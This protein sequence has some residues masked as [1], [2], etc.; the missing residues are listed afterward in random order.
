[1]YNMFLWQFMYDLQKLKQERKKR[2]LS[3]DEKDLESLSKI[4]KKSFDDLDIVT[5]E[6]PQ[7]KSSYDYVFFPITDGGL[8]QEEVEAM[9]MLLAYHFYKNGFDEKTSS[10]FAEK[11]GIFTESDRGGGFLTCKLNDY[12][13]NNIYWGNQF[14]ENLIGT[15]G[16][17]FA[18]T[19]PGYQPG[20]KLGFANIPKNIEKTV[21]CDDIISTGKTIIT[22][23]DIL[24]SVGITPLVFYSAAEK[25]EYKG[26]ENIKKAYPFLPVVTLAK[27][28]LNLETRKTEVVQNS[29]I[30]Y[31]N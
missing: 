9:G 4:V 3:L 12:L 8:K 14:S 21:L 7:G 31:E 5:Y 1:M 20:T 26:R 13:W 28:H 19:F 25:I 16:L 24:I 22:V 23:A 18:E 6:T 30:F 11:T 27:V 15:K 10:I 17:V 2:I 29:K